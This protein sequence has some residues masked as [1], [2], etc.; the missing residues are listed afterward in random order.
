MRLLTLWPDETVD[1][2]T[3]KFLVRHILTV[4]TLCPSAVTSILGAAKQLNQLED[5]NILLDHVIGLGALVAMVYMSECFIKNAWRV[6]KLVEEIRSFE[7][8]FGAGDVVRDT[9]RSVQTFTKVIF[10]LIFFYVHPVHSI[11]LQTL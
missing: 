1:T 3:A 7:E 5:I 8:R 2:L 11:F 4:F 9:E 10:H 6:R